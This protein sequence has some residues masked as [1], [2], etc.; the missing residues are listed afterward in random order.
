VLRTVVNGK[1][2]RIGKSQTVAQK[3]VR[4]WEAGFIPFWDGLPHDLLNSNSKKDTLVLYYTK[5]AKA[6]T[7]LPR[8][9]M[10]RRGF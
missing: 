4:S 8:T 1:L 5:D 3:T 2:T 10:M 6:A 9:L 7:V